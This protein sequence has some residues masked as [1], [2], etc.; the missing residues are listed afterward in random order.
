MS[1]TEQS[2][3]EACSGGSLFFVVF[4]PESQ[5]LQPLALPFAEKVRQAGG[6]A[7]VHCLAGISRSPTLAIA[8]L[9]QFMHMS[10]DDAYR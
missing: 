8:Y 10:S 9:M 4:F 5:L 1:Q 6:R 7:L 2:E 3:L